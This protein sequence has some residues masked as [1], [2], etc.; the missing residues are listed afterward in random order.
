VR[1]FK[2]RRLSP[3]TYHRVTDFALGALV[4]IIVTGAAVR[5]TGSGLGCPDWPVCDK[6]HVVA[7][8]EYHALVE[9]VNRLFTGVVSLAVIAGALGSLLRV[10][11]RRDLTLFASSL[12]L[13]VFAQA[14]LGGLSVK[15]DL[16]PRFVMAHLLLSM[17]IVFLAV[18]LNHRAGQPDGPPRPIVHRD[19]IWLA[20]GMFVLGAIVLFV[21]TMVTGSGPHA[22]AEDVRRLGFAPEEI[23]KVHGLTVWLL[24][25]LTGLTAWRLRVVQASAT[26]V[27]AGEMTMLALFV[28]GGIGYIQY[29]LDV[30]ALLVLVHVA[31]ATAVWILIIRFNL[32]M[33]ERWDPLGVDVYDGDQPGSVSPPI[34]ANTSPV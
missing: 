27:K 31:G 3:E 9:F 7:P 32:A 18:V 13:G 12:V 29:S 26:L 11:R 24:V 17:V 20:R 34:G 16:D 25:G 14:L 4:V 2:Q 5:L 33:Y 30:P 8:L 22:G 28:Q 19:Y 1:G 10:P 23:T 21:G 6:N 15:Y